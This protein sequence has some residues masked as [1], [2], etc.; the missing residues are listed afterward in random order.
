MVIY[1][2]GILFPLF[3]II[4]RKC[5]GGGKMNHCGQ[6]FFN[7]KIQI[8]MQEVQVSKQN[9][10][11][12][13]QQRFVAFSQSNKKSLLILIIQKLMLIGP[14][15]SDCACPHVKQKERLL[16][17][18]SSELNVLAQKRYMSLLVTI[19]WSQGDQGNRLYH[20]PCQD[21]VGSSVI[22]N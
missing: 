16:Q 3:P 5:W 11:D 19:N 12:L 9:F 22:T 1:I 17:S 8:Q 10:S 21:G 15:I 7:I 2:Q 18:L 14:T 4:V 6:R 13:K 20:V